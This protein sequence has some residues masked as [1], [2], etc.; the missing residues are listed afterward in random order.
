MHAR[1]GNT[2]GVVF[3]PPLIGGE[4]IQQIRLL[5]HLRRYGLDLISFSYAGHG[6]SK[7]SFSFQAAFQNCLRMLDLA[8]D[9]SRQQGVPL[10]G[11]ASCF[12]AIPLL[13]ATYARSEPLQKLVLI[14]AIPR[15]RLDKIGSHFLR[16][17]RQSESWRLS[18][19]ELP[20]VMRAYRDDLLPGVTHRPQAFGVLA[21][22]RVQW[23]RLASE[24]LSH[25][26]LPPAAVSQTPVL[27]IYGRKDRILHQ[28]GFYKWQCYES[29]I[30]SICPR[31]RFFPLDGGH[32]LNSPDIR[33]RL[34]NAVVDFFNWTEG[35]ALTP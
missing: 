21:R 10:F 2:R 16:Y 17:W 4:A 23:L 34:T 27:C 3:V 8:S 25:A 33:Y 5:R 19:L 32:F 28:M 1:A 31:T 7:G 30:E 13:Q 26:P 14:N 29:L 18:F 11:L 15:W 22:Q 20:M 9:Y 6:R 24:L 35:A 12:A